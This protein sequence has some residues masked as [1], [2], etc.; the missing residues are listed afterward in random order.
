MIDGSEDSSNR[1]DS[2]ISWD[3]NNGLARRSWARNKGA[4]F[5]ISRA[6]QSDER[7]DVTIPN[8]VD[9]QMLDKVLDSSR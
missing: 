6:M 5:A 9:R 8:I 3:V 1:I 7:L 4:E 2:M